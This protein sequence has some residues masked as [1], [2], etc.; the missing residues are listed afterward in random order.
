[1]EK[2][3]TAHPVKRQTREVSGLY[4]G[5]K[6]EIEV[7]GWGERACWVNLFYPKCS[8][9]VHDTAAGVWL[10]YRLGLNISQL[11]LQGERAAPFRPA[12][13]WASFLRPR[14]N[15]TSDLSHLSARA[16]WLSS[17]HVLYVI[18]NTLHL[19]FQ[20]RGLSQDISLL[21]RVMW[22]ESDLSDRKKQEKICVTYAHTH[23]PGK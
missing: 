12:V 3:T 22:K 7:N 13:T 9:S 10:P 4:D 8:G 5:C 19:W 20:L 2:F 6:G 18:P 15:L 1:M 14:L 16:S 21:S 11:P 23:V 17:S